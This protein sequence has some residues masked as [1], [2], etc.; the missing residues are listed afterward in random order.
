MAE[1]VRTTHLAQMSPHWCWWE[2]IGGKIGRSLSL[3]WLQFESNLTLALHPW[4]LRYDI[5]E[6]QRTPEVFVGPSPGVD[7]KSHFSGWGYLGGSCVG[8][9]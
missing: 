6:D 1:G 3:Q 7:G 5:E 2:L 4:Q 8:Q 9:G